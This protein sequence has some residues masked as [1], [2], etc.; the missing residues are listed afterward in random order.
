MEHAL[1]GPAIVHRVV[2][3]AVVEPVAGDQLVLV[4]VV[5]ERETQLAGEAV[6]VQDQGLGGKANLAGRALQLVQVVLDPPVG[7]AQVVGEEPGLLAVAGEEIAGELEDL[8]VARGLGG[9][10][11]PHGGE[12]EE[13]GAG[14]GATVGEP[15][16][17]VG[18]E[19]YGM[20]EVH[21]PT[22]HPA[23]VSSTTEG[24]AACQVTRCHSSSRPWGNNDRHTTRLSP[25]VY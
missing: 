13:D 25:P 6:L 18:A 1:G 22:F 2:Q 20:F 16:G 8:L 11:D 5:I 12:L 7:G 15:D 10:L 4:P 9:D 21:H 14:G 23:Q 3:H 19:S 24:H 17:A